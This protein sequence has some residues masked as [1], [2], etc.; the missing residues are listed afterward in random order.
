MASVDVVDPSTVRLNL[1]APFSP[2]L[3]A[4]ADRAGM[5]VSPK[6]AQA[7]GDKFGAKPVCSGPFKFV[8]RVAQDRIVLERYAGY[9]NK[10]DVHFDKVVYTPIVDADGAP[11]QPALGPARPHRARRAVRHRR[12]EEA[13]RT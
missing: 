11:R 6:A 7:E 4:L 12:P 1:S 13:T 3:A 8:E 10:A 2:L 5:M 9:W